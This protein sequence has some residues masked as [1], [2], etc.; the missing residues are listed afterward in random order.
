MFV[1]TLLFL[2]TT[3]QLHMLG[4]GFRVA[5]A[6]RLPPLPH[7][8][9]LRPHGRHVLDILLDQAGGHSCQGDA[10]GHLAAHTRLG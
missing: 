1:F 10:R 5:E 6:P 3:R 2:F 9:A 7:L 4:R 8:R